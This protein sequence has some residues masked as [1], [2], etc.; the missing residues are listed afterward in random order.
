LRRA[1]VGLLAGVKLGVH[2]QA[3]F[4]IVDSNGGGLAEPN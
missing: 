1:D 2:Q 4:Q 3:V